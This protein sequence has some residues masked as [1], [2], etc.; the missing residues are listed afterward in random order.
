M[1]TPHLPGPVLDNG[2]PYREQLVRLCGILTEHYPELAGIF[3]GT[4]E[5]AT[6]KER[7]AQEVLAEAEA[8]MQQRIISLP[9]SDHDHRVFALQM[10]GI[11][12]DLIESNAEAREA[13]IKEQRELME[14]G[15]FIAD[16]IRTEHK[17]LLKD[18]IHRLK[19]RDNP[20]VA[21]TI[22]SVLIAT[23]SAAGSIYM[24]MQ[25]GM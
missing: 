2:P 10:I 24:Y 6:Y 18:E 21:A 14:R 12:K 25:S 19:T 1:P 9:G 11:C 5:E 22:L 8:A 4:P 16:N 20:W 3:K 23:A 15:E 7:K 13:H 17:D